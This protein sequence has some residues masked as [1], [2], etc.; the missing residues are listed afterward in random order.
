MALISGISAS[1]TF[2]YNILFE[3]GAVDYSVLP[4]FILY[5]LGN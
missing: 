1:V 4:I 2:L 5:D 3:L